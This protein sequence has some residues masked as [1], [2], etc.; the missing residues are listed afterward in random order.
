MPTGDLI[1]IGLVFHAFVTLVVAIVA[2]ILVAQL[3][4]IPLNTTM[5][6]YAFFWVTTGL[7]WFQNSIRNAFFGLGLLDFP[8]FFSSAL[9]QST[10]YLSGVPLFYYVGMKVFKS[11]RVAFLLALQ[12]TI[13]GLIGSWLLF[14]PEGIIFEPTTQFTIESVANN[15]SGMIFRVEI[16]III[17]L[18]I[19]DIFRR[20]KY[21]LNKIANEDKYEIIYSLAILLYTFLGMIDL[22]K[23]VNSWQLVI[24]RLL[25]C[26]S[27][28]TVYLT[29]RHQREEETKY[30]MEGHIG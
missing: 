29:I 18:L 26:A 27:F 4:S 11:R 7:L 22:M 2:F 14:Q 13:A 21:P 24:F 28:L 17:L 10:V 16:G 5:K 15:V 23:I 25:Y 19:Y 3:L 20:F 6:A 12:T 9:S 8:R 30:L 1:S